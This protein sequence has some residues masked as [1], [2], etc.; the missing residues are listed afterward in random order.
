[1][2]ISPEADT[3]ARTRNL[4]GFCHDEIQYT[5]AEDILSKDL[6]VTIER[7]V[8]FWYAVVKPYE[9]SNTKEAYECLETSFLLTLTFESRIHPERRRW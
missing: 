5:T 4:K 1:V 6:V 9:S 7:I 3:L 2:L 8:E